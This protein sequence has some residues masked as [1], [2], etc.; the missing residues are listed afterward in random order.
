MVPQLVICHKCG[1]V[2]YE[3]I[4][5]KSPDEIIQSYDGKCPTCGKKLSYIPIDAK[6]RSVDETNL[7]SPFEPKRNAQLRTEVGEH[8]EELNRRKRKK[9]SV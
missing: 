3:G 9:E 4:E 6:V 2:L 7:P 8:M 5:L 1:A